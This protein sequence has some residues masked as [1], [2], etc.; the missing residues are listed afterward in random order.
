MKDT[1]NNE[2]PMFL[3]DDSKKRKSTMF[4]RRSRSLEETVVK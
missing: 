1:Y 2:L 3:V 4:Q